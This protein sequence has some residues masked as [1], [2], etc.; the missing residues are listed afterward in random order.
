MS[1]IF[2]KYF[3]G[4]KVIWGIIIALIVVSM[5]AVYSSTGLI[6]FRFKGGNTSY[7]LIRHIKFI[8]LGLIVL[9]IV[10]L[11]PYQVYFKWANAAYLIALGLLLITLL[12]GVS[13]NDATRWLSIPAIGI[14]FQTSDF[15]KFALLMFV[16]KHLAINQKDPQKLSE[17]L[18]I[19]IWATIFMV[20]FILS[21]NLS[22]AILL[23]LTV[24]V[25][26]FIGRVDLKKLGKYTLILSIIGIFGMTIILGSGRFGRANTWKNRIENFI[27]S[28]GDNYQAEMAKIAVSTGGF[29]GKGPGQSTQRNFLPQPYSDFIYAIIIEEYGFLGGAFVL[30]LYLFFM[31][32]VG[33]IVSRS[34]QTFQALLAVGLSVS[35]VIQALFN[36]AVAVNLFPV[37]GQTLPL[38][39]MGGTSIVFTSIALGIVLSISR[40]LEEERLAQQKATA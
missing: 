40:S 11:I 3:K 28:E 15:A 25:I 7:Y 18:D 29:T 12:V 14:E 5:L 31:Y 16:S 37:T 24:F 13:K 27:S 9:Y 8:S 1:G 36:M 30:F 22:T 23:T 32:R 10:H 35:M 21:E 19:I 17:A 2:N 20:L 4:D 39:S 33:V 26:L 38:I 6:A 34:K